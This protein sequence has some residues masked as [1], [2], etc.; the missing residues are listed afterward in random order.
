M[1]FALPSEHPQSPFFF[2][3]RIYLNKPF[4]AAKTQ[5]G[6]GQMLNSVLQSSSLQAAA[7]CDRWYLSFYTFYGAKLFISY[8]KETLF[9]P[10]MFILCQ[11]SCIK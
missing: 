3:A 1:T 5:D 4:L 11:Y 7:M 8:N 2:F 9:P 10:L 6:D